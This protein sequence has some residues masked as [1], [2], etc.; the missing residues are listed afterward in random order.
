MKAIVYDEYGDPEALRMD[1]VD[2]PEP[3][4]DEVL[5]QVEAVALNASDGEFLR[6]SPA[7]VRMWGPRRPRYRV[8]GS[9]VAG[10]VV[11]VGRAATRF[12]PGDAVLTDTFER[13]GGLAE[14]VVAPEKKCVAKPEGLTFEQAAA[15]PQSGVLA[16]QA[17]L[18]GNGPGGERVLINGAGGGAGAGATGTG[19]GAGAEPPRWGAS[20]DG[21]LESSGSSSSESSELESI[22]AA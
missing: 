22:P 19:G 5:I 16:L 4:D 10:R 14:Y 11:A 7:Y 6:G 9:D 21:R 15:T 2:R 3:R 20:A 17:L 13:W 8:L 1:E 12:R 18:R